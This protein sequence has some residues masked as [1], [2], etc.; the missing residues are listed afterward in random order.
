MIFL[1]YTFKRLAFLLSLW[2]VFLSIFVSGN[3]LSTSNY[4]CYQTDGLM[5]IGE[6]K[7]SFSVIYLLLHQKHTLSLK[8]GKN[9]VLRLTFRGLENFPFLFLYQ[10]TDFVCWFVCFKWFCFVLFKCFKLFKI[11]Y[12]H[13]VLSLTQAQS[14]L[15]KLGAVEPAVEYVGDYTKLAGL[16]A[17]EIACT[18]EGRIIMIRSRFMCLE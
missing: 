14:L 13:A 11:D 6:I 4:Q 9:H 1:I 5:D 8:T 7:F 16:C 17:S 2:D 15:L 3:L 12:F 10:F 18:R